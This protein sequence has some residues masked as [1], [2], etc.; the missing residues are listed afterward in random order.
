[1]KRRPYLQH[2]LTKGS[3][4]VPK[5]CDYYSYGLRKQN[6]AELL[7]SPI[8]LKLLSPTSS[9]HTGKARTHVY[10][11]TQAYFAFSDSA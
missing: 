1:M 7:V 11:C 3:A 10:C 9:Y 5:L 8:Q 2:F 4:D 6:W